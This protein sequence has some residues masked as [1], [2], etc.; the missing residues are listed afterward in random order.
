MEL[1][2]LFEKQ[3]QLEA[4]IERNHPVRPGENRL[5]KQLLALIVELAEAANDWRGFKYWSVDQEAKETLLEEYCDVLHLFLAI[6]LRIGKTELPEGFVMLASEDVEDC[7][8]D[9][10]EEVPQIEWSSY[11]WNFSFYRFLEL[12]DLLGFN[13]EQISDAYMAKHEINWQRQEAGY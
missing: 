7:L 13:W 1:S 3:Q 2:A 12:G 11:C 4:E 6:G 9:I 10:F 5:K 8:L